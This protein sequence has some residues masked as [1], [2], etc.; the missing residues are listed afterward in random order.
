M[1]LILVEYLKMV[2]GHYGIDALQVSG[3]KYIV[4]ITLKTHLT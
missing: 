4:V 2:I 3:S 1:V